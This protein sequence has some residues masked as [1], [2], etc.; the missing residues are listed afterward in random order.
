MPVFMVKPQPTPVSPQNPTW[1]SSDMPTKARSFW[2]QFE[3]PDAGR[4][5][6]SLP[7][8]HAAG[9]VEAAALARG[10][11]HQ[12]VDAGPESGG[13]VL[14]IP[15]PALSRIGGVGER[16]DV[17]VGE[18]ITTVGSA[19]VDLALDVQNA[20]RLSAMLTQAVAAHGQGV[21]TGLRAIAGP[22]AGD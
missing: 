9:N 21:T 3:E 19:G 11:H 2:G 16:S 20:L 4:T 12:P 8:P 13:A 10:A 15:K 5:A 6:V 18:E 17:D 1:L 7:H 22:L 14:G